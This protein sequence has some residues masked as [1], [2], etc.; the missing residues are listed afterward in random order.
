MGDAGCEHA[1][2]A[3]SSPG[4]NENRPLQRL[5]RPQLLFIQTVEITWAPAARYVENTWVGRA[6]GPPSFERRN[7]RWVAYL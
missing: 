6:S 5:D 7:N 2:F 4:E 1:G 3:N